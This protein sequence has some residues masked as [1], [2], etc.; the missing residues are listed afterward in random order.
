MRPAPV[1]RSTRGIR[2]IRGIRGGTG[3]AFLTTAALTASACGGSGSIT[4]KEGAA[5]VAPSDNAAL[6]AALVALPQDL[7]TYAASAP[8]G[9]R[10]GLGAIATVRDL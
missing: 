2:G 9:E 6:C 5:R 1:R 10:A 8:K 7:E 4:P 3:M